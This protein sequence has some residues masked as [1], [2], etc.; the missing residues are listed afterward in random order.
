VNFGCDFFGELHI[1]DVFVL[2][3]SAAFPPNTRPQSHKR[4]KRRCM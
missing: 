4:G 2:F 3:P 1:V